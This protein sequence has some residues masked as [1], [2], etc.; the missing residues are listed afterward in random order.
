MKYKITH[1]QYKITHRCTTDNLGLRER[2]AGECVQ[3]G[4]LQG[5]V[6]R[7]PIFLLASVVLLPLPLAATSPSHGPMGISSHVQGLLASICRIHAGYSAHLL[8]D[9]HDPQRL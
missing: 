1:I 7:I 4:A 9:S 6:H 5:A 2:R 8:L 3:G